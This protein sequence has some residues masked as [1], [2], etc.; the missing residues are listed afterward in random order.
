[1]VIILQILCEDSSVE[2]NKIA[3]K[4]QD[5]NS[6]LS[7]EIRTDVIQN[8]NN[9]TEKENDKFISEKNNINE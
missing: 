6:E 9:K 2:T 4:G 7:R 1:M 3:V 5:K 8:S